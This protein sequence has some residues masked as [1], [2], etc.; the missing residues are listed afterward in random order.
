MQ[1]R[2]RV[3]YTTR[4]TVEGP[5]VEVPDPVERDEAR[6]APPHEARAPPPCAQAPTPRAPRGKWSSKMRSNEGWSS[7]V[8]RRDSPSRWFLP[9]GARPGGAVVRGGVGASLADEGQ[10]AHGES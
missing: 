2:L 6:M 5:R 10:Q 4:K 7:E 3:A 1:A 9:T 8:T